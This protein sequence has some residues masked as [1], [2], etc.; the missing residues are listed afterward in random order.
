MYAVIE[1]GSKQ[2]TVKVGDVL[3]VEKQAGKNG[4]TLTIDKVL[5]ISGDDI[6]VGQPYVKGASIGATVI[7]DEA[8]GE[9]LI[10]FKYRRRKNSHW[11]KGHRQKLTRIKIESIKI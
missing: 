6:K 7:D 3:D 2:Y 9:K 1:I 8:K 4:D 5:L 11:K 10:S